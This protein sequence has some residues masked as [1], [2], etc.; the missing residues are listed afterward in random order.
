M[1]FR[2]MNARQE[3]VLLVIDEAHNLHRFSLHPESYQLAL[4]CL[5]KQVKKQK[6][7]MRNYHFH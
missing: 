7:L 4:N 2:R 3:N 5:K 6:Q 1:L